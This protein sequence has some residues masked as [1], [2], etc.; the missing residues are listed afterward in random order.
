MDQRFLR[1]NEYKI[2]LAIPNGEILEGQLPNRQMKLLQAWIE[3]HQDE[4]M[5]DWFLAS[6][7]QT[8]F[9]IDPLR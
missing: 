2:V 1:Y 5:A 4:L 7:G 8:P 6:S 3:L 9:K